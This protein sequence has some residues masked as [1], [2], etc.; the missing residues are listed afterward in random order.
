VSHWPLQKRAHRSWLSR[1]QA[2]VGMATG[3]CG[4][5]RRAVGPA[6]ANE[7]SRFNH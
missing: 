2:C 4:V 7:C 5:P 1:A 3:A 6:C